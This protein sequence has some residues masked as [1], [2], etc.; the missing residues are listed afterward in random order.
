MH[1]IFRRFNNEK[2]SDHFLHQRKSKEM[3]SKKWELR[4]NKFTFLV[5]FI[6]SL[7]LALSCV[8]EEERINSAPGL[9][10]IFSTDTVQFDTVFTGSPQQIRNI[11]KRLMVFNTQE[12]A[13]EISS[14]ALGRGN[15]SP[16]SL[17]VNGLQQ[18][19]LHN[20]LLL[21]GDSLLILVNL[22]AGAEDKSAPFLIKDSI[23]FEVNGNIQDV[24]LWAY[25]QDAIFIPKGTLPCHQTW[26]GERPYIIQDTVWVG[27]DCTLTIHKGAQLFFNNNAALMVA[28][29][30]K[31]LGEQEERV[32]FSNSRLDIKNEIGLWA[33]LHFLPESHDHEIYFA[34]IRNATTGIFLET[35]DTDTLPDLIIGNTKI[36]N[37]ARYGI[38][39]RGADIYVYN[40]L[41]NTALE[42]VVKN[43]GGGN[44]T[45]EHCTL[46]NYTT[47]GFSPQYPTVFFSNI[48]QGEAPLNPLKVK[49]YN[50][51]IWS[52][53]NLSYKSDLNFSLEGNN[54]LIDQGCN[55]IRSRDE[56][57]ANKH[58]I[59][60]SKP[61]FPQFLRAMQYNYQLDSLSP[62]IN[63][64]KNLNI[65]QDIEGN[66]R[67][68]MPDIGAYEYN[69]P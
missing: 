50:N 68:D 7:S 42:N 57:Q 17:F 29:T 62:A 52:A 14:I 18:Q 53:G 9:K 41:I 38:Y 55:L 30:L 63:K 65:M 66:E 44:Y 5:F 22:Q 43:E 28:G 4:F 21:G 35:N 3:L 40:S 60:D 56:S 51:I 27:P 20:E 6:L 15:V 11:T 39:A 16:Y 36:E 58:N 12:R 61:D 24:K 8:P 25:G 59:L 1:L 34:T 33:G 37:M 47:L 32:L 13:L 45:Y 64:G 19:S 26:K 48:A 67:D 23:V 54:Y 46:V 69:G 2:I 10:L 49:L 31:V